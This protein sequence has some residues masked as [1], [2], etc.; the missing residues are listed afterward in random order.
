MVSAYHGNLPTTSRDAW[1]GEIVIMQTTMQP[2]A[3]EF[4]EIIF[5]YDI[6]RLGRRVDVV[7][8]LRGIIFCLEFKVGESKM[9]QN[10]IEQV[11]DYALDLKN[12]HKL[13]WDRTIVPILVPTRY[14]SSSSEFFPSVYDDAIYN[15][16]VVGANG[17]KSL[18]SKVLDH[19]KAY[20]PDYSLGADWII[21]PY[22]PTPTIVEAART[23]YENH[24][25][26]DITRHE[27]I[28]TRL[29]VIFSKSS[30]GAGRT[31]KRA[32]ASSQASRAQEKLWW[33]LTSQSSSR[34]REG[35][36]LW[37][38]KRLSISQATGRLWRC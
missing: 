33:D 34:I 30:T 13:S 5:E 18:I 35:K 2:W 17:L 27:E 29:S 7:L 1:E 26:E 38:T 37:K 31:P 23:L 28:R 24:S 20:S 36:I 6:P 14:S 16:L 10:D 32:S 22:A 8:L 11:L 3:D 9:L 19:A 4:G 21:S 12:F 15:P 25:V